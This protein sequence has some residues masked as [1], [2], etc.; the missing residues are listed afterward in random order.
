MTSR[1]PWGQNSGMRLSLGREAGCSFAH[2]C[3]LCGGWAGPQRWLVALNGWMGRPA[4]F[5]WRGGLCSAPRQ[6]VGMC[7]VDGDERLQQ[8]VSEHCF[9]SRNNGLI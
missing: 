6:V 4:R 3:G 9:E 1:H 7:P 8:V 2:F 5:Q